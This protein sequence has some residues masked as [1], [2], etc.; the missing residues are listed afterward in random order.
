MKKTIEQCLEEVGTST[1]HLDDYDVVMLRFGDLKKAMHEFASQSQWI[2][3]SERL[4]DENV[5]VLIHRRRPFH[6]YP[7][8]AFLRNG[9][10]YCDLTEHVLTNVINWQPLTLKNIK[11]RR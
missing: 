6:L 1:D 11:K 2:A 7:L 5:K 9:V 10:F 4:P 8:I 3:V